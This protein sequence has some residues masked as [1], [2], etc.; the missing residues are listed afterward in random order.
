MQASGR[1][2]GAQE[3]GWWVRPQWH[4][5]CRASHYRDMADCDKV[6]SVKPRRHNSI[7]KIHRILIEKIS[8]SPRPSASCQIMAGRFDP[9]IHACNSAEGRYTRA[10]GR[11]EVCLGPP[12]IGAQDSI[13]TICRHIDWR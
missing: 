7:A 13:D 5:A 1:L 9:L 8:V 11:I 4:G 6:E 2:C 3:R 10:D 12:P